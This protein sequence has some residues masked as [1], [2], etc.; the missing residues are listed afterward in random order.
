MIK[1]SFYPVNLL[2]TLKLFSNEGKVQ[3]F[4]RKG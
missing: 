1:N 2:F 4:A 3:Y